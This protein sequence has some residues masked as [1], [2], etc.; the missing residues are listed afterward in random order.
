VGRILSMINGEGYG[1]T[2]SWLILRLI[3][4]T[5]KIIM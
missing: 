1:K 3:P 4:K 5:I 2:R